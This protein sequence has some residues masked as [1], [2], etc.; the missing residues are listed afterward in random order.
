MNILY[1]KVILIFLLSLNLSATSLKSILYMTLQNNDNIKAINYEI[2]SKKQTLKSVSNIF[3]P[4][5]KVGANYSKINGDLPANAIGSTTLGFLKFNAVLYNGGKNV[6]IK[7]IKHYQLNSARLNANYTKKDIL[8][9]DIT[10]FYQIKTI[11]ESIKAYKEKSKSLYSQYKRRKTKYDIGML[12]IDDVLRLKSEYESNKYIIDE[13][14][15]QKESLYQNLSLLC[16]KRIKSIDNSKIKDI[17]HLKYRA[18]SAIKALQEGVKI[19]NE[20]INIAKAAKRP[21][22]TVE[23]SLNVYKYANYNKNVFKDLPSTQNKVTLNFSMTILDSST[24]AKKESAILSKLEKSTQLNYAI[25][26]EKIAFNLAIKKLYT[27]KKKIYS[28]KSALNMANSAYKIIKTKY[29]NGV[30]D[31]ITYLDALSKKI[32]YQT[33]Y[34]QALNNYEIAKANYYFSSGLSYKDI[35]KMIDR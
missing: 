14:E 25:K 9:Q 11:E 6:A 2:E 16:G 5:L 15:Y 12:T 22:V 4:T 10:L 29:K 35:F 27:Q 8:L 26:K 28:A 7:K 30:V 17:P 1:K 13:L 20:N 23:D 32:M 18:S 21:K 3:M 33:L 31:N 34:K 19:A 24:S